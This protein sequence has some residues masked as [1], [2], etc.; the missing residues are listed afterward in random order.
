MEAR[1]D[2][3]PC[4]RNVEDYVDAVVPISEVVGARQ[5]SSTFPY[6]NLIG[7]TVRFSDEPLRLYNRPESADE[8]EQTL[9]AFVT[10]FVTRV[11]KCGLQWKHP[12]LDGEF[13]YTTGPPP[14]P[15]LDLIEYHLSETETLALSPFDVYDI[16]Y[17]CAVDFNDHDGNTPQSGN[18]KKLT[19]FLKERG[20]PCV[21]VKSGSNDGYH[22]FIPIV[23]TKTL[24][25]HKFL[26]Q[27]IKDTGLGDHK[28]IKR[29]P[30]QK[31]SSS[32]GGDYGSQ[33]MLPVGFNWKAGKKSTV[34][35]PYSL[36]PVEFVEVTHAVKLRDLPDPA[37]TESKK[38][39]R[40]FRCQGS[41]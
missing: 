33:I 13:G 1:A 21:V 35:D 24:V 22:V 16:C 27:L 41:G 28:E 19:G 12:N 38:S 20:L 40:A 26:K 5:K 36:E 34:V 30:K 15:F 32:T 3:R 17:F 10:V 14:K 31:S 7:D 11:D 23:P 6:N 4:R 37:K 29:H 25:V 8:F 2:L 18:V 39:A 9:F